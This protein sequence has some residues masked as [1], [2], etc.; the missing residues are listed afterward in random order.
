MQLKDFAGEVLVEARLL[1]RPA[2]AR[3]LGEHGAGA[4]RLRLIEVEQHARMALH[5]E[6]HVR[7]LAQHM[8][9]DR[10]VLESPGKAERG[11]LVDR[12]GEMVRPESDEPI[13]ERRLAGNECGVARA[14]SGQIGIAQG[15]EDLGFRIGRR[16][17]PL[18]HLGLRFLAL[19][20]R[21]ADLLEQAH[22][23]LRSG[24]R[25]DGWRTRLVLCHLVKQPAPG[26]AVGLV[27]A[28]TA[29]AEAIEGDLPVLHRRL[30]FPRA[31]CLP[32]NL[33]VR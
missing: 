7:E 13:H 19:L 23:L 28:R 18:G 1:I 31:A 16:G 25:G 2:L 29:K 6:Q 33:I 11:G 21:L 8:R 5:R 15:L 30:L 10:L 32:V 26:I 14:R 24:Q 27:C 20:A 9:A 12:Y 3:T 22:C 4:D 17:H